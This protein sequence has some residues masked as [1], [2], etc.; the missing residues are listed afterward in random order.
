MSRRASR[1]RSHLW[2]QLHIQGLLRGQ[3]PTTRFVVISTIRSGSTMLVDLI[4]SHPAA[5]CFYELFHIHPDAIPF[6]KQGYELLATSAAALDLRRRDPWAFL[7]RYVWAPVHRSGTQAVG[8]KLHYA[9]ARQDS[10]WHED[11]YAGMW[12]ACGIPPLYGDRDHDLWQHL[13]QDCDVRIVHLIRTNI[14][15]SMV[16]SQT[17]QRTASWGDQASGGYRSSDDIRVRIEPDHLRHALQQ[18]QRFQGEIDSWFAEHPLLTLTYEDLVGQRQQQLDRVFDFLGL[19]RRE[20]V[21]S[22]RKLRTTSLR[23]SILNVDELAAACS[24][25]LPPERFEAFLQE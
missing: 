20:I 21:P 14:L 19:E 13:R 18:Q 1:L 2:R 17:A 3:A 22:T 15:A 4:D 8:F 10:W 7:L 5:E 24:D 16:S 6:A 12:H 25:V 23:E 11:T 9:Q